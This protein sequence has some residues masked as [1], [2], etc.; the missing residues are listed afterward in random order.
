M[1]IKHILVAEYT[2][3]RF[4]TCITIGKEI[5]NQNEQP[6]RVKVQLTSCSMLS[7]SR[8]VVR[9]RSTQ[10]L[11][12]FTMNLSSSLILS[13][14]NSTQPIINHSRNL[15]PHTQ[16]H[17]NTS[18]ADSYRLDRRIGE[19]RLGGRL[20]DDERRHERGHLGLHS[21]TTERDELGAVRLP[22]VR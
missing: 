16:Q 3:L 8:S 6:H 5:A 11:L 2:H 19:W 1:D 17:R 10:S 7:L 15:A 13:S 22:S 20:P 21:N 18:T 12:C 9:C 14:Y 4:L